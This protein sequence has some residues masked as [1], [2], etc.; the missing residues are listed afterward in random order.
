MDL[1]SASLSCLQYAFDHD[2]VI[3]LLAPDCPPVSDE[4][5]NH[6]QRKKL[7][8]ISQYK[9][10]KSVSYILSYAL[11]PDGFALVESERNKAK[12]KEEAKEFEKLQREEILAAIDY[13]K[14]DLQLGRKANRISKISLFLA[15]ASL[16]ISALTYIFK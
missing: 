1:D 2:G 4:I 16:L 6:L 5:L 7:L 9:E 14:K 11:T 15:L 8:R 10:S 12:E 3:N 13:Y